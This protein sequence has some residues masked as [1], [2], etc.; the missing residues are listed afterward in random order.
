MFAR[1]RANT[2]IPVISICYTHPELPGHTVFQFLSLLALHPV[3]D[4]IL[5]DMT[6]IEDCC[7]HIKP[8]WK[9]FLD[10]D[11]HTQ[12]TGNPSAGLAHANIVSAFPGSAARYQATLLTGIHAS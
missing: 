6:N 12:P 4:F 9:A 10:H 3:V 2:R 7:G 8:A 11:L 5:A 1:T